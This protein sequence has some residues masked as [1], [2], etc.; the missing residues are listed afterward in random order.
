MKKDNQVTKVFIEWLI[1]GRASILAYSGE[2]S[3]TKY[4]LLTEDLKLTELTNTVQ[5]Y[6]SEGVSY[7]RNQQEY[8]NILLYNFRDCPPLETQIKS[9]ALKGK[10][11]LR[12]TKQYH[13]MTCKTEDCVVFEEKGRN[14]VFEWGVYTGFLNSKWILNSDLPEKVDPV[15]SI[16]LGLALNI[17]NLPALSPKFSVKVNLALFS[18]MYIYDTTDI[19]PLIT[20]NRI[21]KLGYAKIPVQ[22]SYR[23]NQKKFSPYISAGVTV[24]VRYSYKQY[25]Q[26]LTDWIVR[27]GPSNPYSSKVKPIQ[28]GFNSGLGCEYIFSP[29]LKF[30]LGYDFEF[31]PRLYGTYID[32]RSMVLNN[33]VYLRAYFF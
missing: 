19:M 12:L 23:F 30:N 13:E 4:Y 20:D 22:L 24:N 29:G 2:G 32:D 6:V 15:N 5:E 8:K 18:S 11:L 17:S 10:S 33:I 27:S 16:G 26:H 3:E 25:D 21:V 9:T 7:Q 28:F 31:A 1:K 14:M